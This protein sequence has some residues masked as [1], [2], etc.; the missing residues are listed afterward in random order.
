M[1]DDGSSI[2]LKVFPCIHLEAIY[3]VGC[4]VEITLG[5]TSQAVLP[6]GSRQQ[7]EPPSHPE[8]YGPLVPILEHR[9]F[10]PETCLSCKNQVPWAPPTQ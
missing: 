5:S 10:G 1:C 8:T 9:N 7:E 3:L 4:G 2:Y 6:S